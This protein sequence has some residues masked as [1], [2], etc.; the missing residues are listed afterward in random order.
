[1]SK[2][3]DSLLRQ[4][5]WNS[6]YDLTRDAAMGALK[7]LKLVHLI[8]GKYLRF[9]GE[10]K[11]CTR[12]GHEVGPDCTRQSFVH[13]SKLCARRLE[14]KLCAPPLIGV[15]TK[16]LMLFLRWLLNVT[17]TPRLLLTKKSCGKE[18]LSDLGKPRRR[19][20]IWW[21]SCRLTKI[22]RLDKLVDGKSSVV[23]I[24]FVAKSV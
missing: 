20:N 18:P 12:N 15:D 11:H 14:V 7:F 3:S 2:F 4:V 1:M 19:S 21:K 22:T 8:S 5:L 9:L 10:T 17:P 23:V 6:F 16:S 24:S 13:C